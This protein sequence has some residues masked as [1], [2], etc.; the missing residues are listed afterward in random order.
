MQVMRTPPGPDGSPASSSSV[1]PAALDM[2]FPKRRSSFRLRSFAVCSPSLAIAPRIIPLR[3][4][5][6]NATLAEMRAVAALAAAVLAAAACSSAPKRRPPAPMSKLAKA[7]IRTAKTYLPEEEKRR[8]P[9]K[10]CSDFVG[11]VFS[12]HGIRLPRT[13]LEMSTEGAPVA[14]S[15]QLRMGDLVFFS[16]EKI[17]RAVGHVGI[18]VNNGIFIHRPDVG[19]VR[20]ESLYSDYFRK[21]YL[22]ARRVID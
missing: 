1:I 8:D 2:P 16:S 5:D 9:P 18:Y 13:S 14:S 21:R 17:S 19:E 4:R 22:S 20:L 7:V 3:R 15:K 10:D 12:E 11:K 6:G